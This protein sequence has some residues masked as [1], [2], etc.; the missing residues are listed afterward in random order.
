MLNMTKKEFERA[1]KKEVKKD[2]ESK[3]IKKRR[4]EAEVVIDPV[5][6][7]KVSNA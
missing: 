7:L 3:K 4:I 6:S 5:R 1:L 2:P